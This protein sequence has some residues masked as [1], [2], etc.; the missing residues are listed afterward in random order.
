MI[1]ADAQALMRMQ[2]EDGRVFEDIIKRI[3]TDVLREGEACLDGG[4]ANGLHTVPMARLVGSRGTVYAVEA[5]SSAA[6]R[7]EDVLRGLK[8]TQ[9]SVINRALYHEACSVP[10]RIVTNALSRSGIA[11]TWYPFEPEIEEVM[12]ETILIDDIVSDAVDWRFCKLDLE[13]GEFRAL[14]GG[15]NAIARHRP[16]LVFERSVAAPEWYGYSP[17]LFFA[18]FRELDYRVFDLFG[19]ELTADTWGEH[20]RPWYA[21]GVRQGSPDEAFVQK[22][23]PSVLSS[24]LDADPS[25]A[26]P[27]PERAASGGPFIWAAP[28]PVPGGN[29]AGTTVVH[30]DSGE[31]DGE[32]WISVNGDE[33]KLFFR[34]ARGSRS[35]PWINEWGNYEFR[36]Y[37]DQDHQE[38]L[39]SVTVTRRTH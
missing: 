17:E 13:G 20:G 26:T 35:A 18:F 19:T 33:E 5:L 39:D 38:L 21:L 12:V 24:F 16:F 3:Y 37:A 7:L 29:G 11:E 32:V 23:L 31:Q 6:S 15:R 1:P 10:F 28:N 8:L 14:Q 22:R 34:S 2:Q 9:V 4:A 27:F 36:L 30:W 25:R